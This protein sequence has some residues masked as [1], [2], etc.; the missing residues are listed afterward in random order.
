MARR[1]FRLVLAVCQ[2]RLKKCVDVL[3]E[4]RCTITLHNSLHRAEKFCLS[5]LFIMLIKFKYSNEY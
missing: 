4:L 1:I 2:Q 5:L 3:S